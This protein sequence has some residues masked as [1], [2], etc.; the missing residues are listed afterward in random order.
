MKEISV[1]ILLVILGI[2]IPLAVGEVIVRIFDIPPRPM[3]SSINIYQL[4]DD[5][6]IGYGYRP[7]YKVSYTAQS[8]ANKG[9]EINRDGFRDIEYPVKKPGNTYR[10]V[11]LGDSTT[12]GNGIPLLSDIYAKQLEIMLNQQKDRHY[13][14]LNMGVGGYQTVQEVELLENRGLNYD[15]D[16]VVLTVCLNDFDLHS[17][18]GV[19]EELL[20]E[21]KGYQ[22]PPKAFRFVLNHSR[23]AFMIYYR[24]LSGFSRI[25][26]WQWY[27]RS[28]LRGRDPVQAGLSTL[29]A[30]QQKRRFSVVVVV[31]PYFDAHFSQYSHLPLH[32][33]I[34]DLVRSVAGFKYIDMLDIFSSV[35]ND[36]ATFS[37]DGCHMN[38]Y[39]H[40]IVAQSLF[41]NISS[42]VRH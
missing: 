9:F 15:P 17:D 37:F 8:S 19:Y 35:D 25:P 11:I 2:M 23:L 28:V 1:R 31:L 16:L 30:L 7:G 13:E 40:R 10:I 6:I 12:A 21:N 26:Y 42:F 5:P 4:S 20:N 33:K 3:A 34:H 14:V 38:S 29:A 32:A 36:A 24:I 22:L 27:E 18:G 41:S 39:G